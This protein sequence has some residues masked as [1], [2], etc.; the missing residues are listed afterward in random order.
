MVLGYAIIGVLLLIVAV[1]IAHLRTVSRPAR[2]RTAATYIVAIA[3]VAVVAVAT[4]TGERAHA[5]SAA[6]TAGVALTAPQSRVLDSIA[7]HA[8]SGLRGS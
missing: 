2:L 3:A 7:K 6:A 4:H 8:V 1:G 5:L